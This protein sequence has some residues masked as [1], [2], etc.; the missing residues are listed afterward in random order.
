[1]S[2]RYRV[3]SG[4][5]GRKQIQID[6][7]PSQ[8]DQI[9]TF[10]YRSEAW[11]RP[12]GE[13]RPTRAVIEA[14]TD[15]PIFPSDLLELDVCWRFQDS[16]GLPFTTALGKFEALR[17]EILADEWPQEKIIMSSGVGATRDDF[18]DGL[19]VNTDG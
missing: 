17:D 14:D 3:V 4:P 16:H 19:R 8:N 13:D 18:L 1:M 10:V 2:Y 7:V 15:I 5:V 11:L 6:P 12:D 9:L